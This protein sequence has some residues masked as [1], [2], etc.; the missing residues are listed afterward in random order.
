MEAGG[1]GEGKGA[2]QDVLGRVSSNHAPLHHITSQAE[3]GP[4]VTSQVLAV[5]VTQQGT[6]PAPELKLFCLLGPGL[7]SHRGTIAG[8]VGLSYGV[9]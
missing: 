1:I 4:Q 2:P 8:R 3:A 6:D 7:R 9:R 5:L